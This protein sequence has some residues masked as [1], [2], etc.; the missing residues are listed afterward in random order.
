M[1]RKPRAAGGTTRPLEPSFE[2]QVTIVDE[3]EGTI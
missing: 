2:P 1:N 3:R